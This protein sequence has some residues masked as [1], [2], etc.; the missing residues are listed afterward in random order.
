VRRFVAIFV[1]VALL[2]ALWDGLTNLAGYAVIAGVSIGLLAWIT[3]RAAHGENV[4]DRG[5][6]RRTAL[7]TRQPR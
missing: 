4:L 5:D 3:H 6:P 7:S 2:H 1:T